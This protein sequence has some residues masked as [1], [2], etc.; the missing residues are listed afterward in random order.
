MAGKVNGQI[1]AEEAI[2]FAKISQMIAFPYLINSIH[3]LPH[4]K[5]KKYKNYPDRINAFFDS[6]LIFLALIDYMKIQPTLGYAFK[7]ICAFC[8]KNFPKAQP[9]KATFFIVHGS[10]SYSNDLLTTSW[11]EEFKIPIA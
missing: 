5:S 1:A 8:D 4:P 6:L 2:L 3:Q 7:A 10:F 9:E 11:R